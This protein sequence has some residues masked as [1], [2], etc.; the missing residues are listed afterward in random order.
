M[1]NINI[2]QL[3]S[4]ISRVMKDVESGETYEVMRYSKPVAVITA[5]AKSKKISDDKC[6][7]C[8]QKMDQIIMLLSLKG[9]KIDAK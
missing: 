1:K 3:Q 7:S 9:E 5:K 6:D 2:N 8:T 4:Q